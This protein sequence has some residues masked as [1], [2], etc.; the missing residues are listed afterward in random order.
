[1]TATA[2]DTAK[3]ADN[4]ITERENLLKRA[5]NVRSVADTLA[6][7]E[8]SD[9]DM[10]V[11]VCFYITDSHGHLQAG[12]EPAICSAVIP[13]SG[14][15]KRDMRVNYTP[16][17]KHMFADASRENLRAVMRIQLYGYDEPDVYAFEQMNSIDA[18]SST[19]TFEFHDTTARDISIRSAAPSVFKIDVDFLKDRSC[20][21][22]AVRFTYRELEHDELSDLLQKEA[23]RAHAS[24]MMAAV[25][26]LDVT[27]CKRCKCT[28]K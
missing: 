26:S 18:D 14:M 22:T 1:M 12:T 4:E 7:G 5:R 9:A 15:T 21:I 6:M 19:A 11:S 17:L 20:I 10:H 13:L 23:R 2:T 25:A 3:T 27:T 16:A 8:A 28:E 24:E